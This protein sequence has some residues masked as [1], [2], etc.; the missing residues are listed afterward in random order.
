MPVWHSARFSSHVHRGDEQ[1]K[2]T[3]DPPAL[4]LAL[5][6]LVAACMCAAIVSGM[7]T[8][9][10]ILCANMTCRTEPLSSLLA[11]LLSSY[12]IDNLLVPMPCAGNSGCFPRGKANSDS[13]A[14]PP[15]PPPTCVQCFRVSVPPAV[16][17]T[18]LR[19]L[20]MGSFNVC[21]NLGA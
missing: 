3:R 4:C 9:E 6:V 21:T 7:H 18:L 14:L 20:D 1:R 2:V 8:L 13:T 12:I 15:P 10:T 16:R 11:F 19:Q 17:P 5:H